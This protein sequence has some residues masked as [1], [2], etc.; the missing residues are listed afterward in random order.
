MNVKAQ[1]DQPISMLTKGQRVETY[2]VIVLL[3]QTKDPTRYCSESSALSRL[4][5]TE[6]TNSQTLCS[7]NREVDLF[8]PQ[9][10][11]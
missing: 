8:P 1:N 10:K 3:P 6:V 4:L 7:R 2:K 9:T 5:S 11:V